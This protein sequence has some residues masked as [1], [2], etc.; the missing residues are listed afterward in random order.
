MG[1]NRVSQQQR[2]RRAATPQTVGDD[3]HAATELPPPPEQELERATAA[4]DRARARAARTLR[5]SRRQRQPQ[6]R[7]A[8]DLAVHPERPQTLQ[9]GQERR[10]WA[11]L[12]PA[13]QR[14]LREAVAALVADDAVDKL[15]GLVGLLNRIRARRN[16]RRGGEPREPV[17]IDR[18]AVRE[19]VAHGVELGLEAGVEHLL[20]TVLAALFGEPVESEPDANP[21]GPLQGPPEMGRLDP[22]ERRFVLE[23]PPI[24]FG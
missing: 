10:I 4:V 8:L 9:E 19:A 16:E 13:E 1:D 23:L 11:Q 2:V 7:P 14:S 12:R 24:P 15:D 20:R 17:G 3:G 21:L 18:Q 5:W 22:G 6:P